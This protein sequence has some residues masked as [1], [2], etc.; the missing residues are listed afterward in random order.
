MQNARKFKLVGKN[1]HGELYMN[2]LKRRVSF[3][4]ALDICNQARDAGHTFS[5]VFD[6]DDNYLVGVLPW[7]QTLNQDEAMLQEAKDF[8]KVGV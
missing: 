3:R 5:M 7:D 1:Q 6:E 2:T 8:L 4:R